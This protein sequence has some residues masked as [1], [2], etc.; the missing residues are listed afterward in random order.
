MTSR[1]ALYMGAVRIFHSPEYA[2]GYFY[3]QFLTAFV[4]IDPVNVRT[5]FEV[6]SFTRS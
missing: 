4:R 3:R 1:C 5:E 6:H 2:H